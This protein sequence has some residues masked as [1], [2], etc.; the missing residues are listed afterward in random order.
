MSLLIKYLRNEKSNTL[1]ALAVT[2]NALALIVTL[3][4]VGCAKV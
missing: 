4:A 1:E 3:L 2:V